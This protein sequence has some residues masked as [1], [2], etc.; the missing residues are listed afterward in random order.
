MSTTSYNTWKQQRT[1][2]KKSR[3]RQRTDRTQFS[4]LLRN[5]AR[6]MESGLLIDSWRQQPARDNTGQFI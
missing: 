3:R 6:K 2:S 4:R 5:L 1:Q